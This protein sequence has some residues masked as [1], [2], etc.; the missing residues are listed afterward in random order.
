[1]IGW[2]VA[3]GESPRPREWWGVSLALVG[4]ALLA[5]PGATAPDPFG[6]GLMAA[7]GLAWAA[8]SLRGRAARD[9]LAANADNFVRGTLLSLAVALLVTRR[10]LAPGG[11]ALAV[12]SGAV[13]SGLGYTLW[14][15]AL[16]G[17]RRTQAAV[18][19]LAVPV[20][21]AA[22]GVLLLGESL[23]LRL[24]ACGAVILGGIAIALTAR[25]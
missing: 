17:L 2:G 11:L 7:A 19:Q 9:P 8:Y 6:L 21:A 20:L 10:Q 23:T 1:M 5:R 25:A 24:A 22:G 14:Y 18:V 16:R 15:A 4:L 13:A 12:A 3:E